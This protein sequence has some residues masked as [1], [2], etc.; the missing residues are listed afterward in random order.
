[1]N[2]ASRKTASSTR[3]R[4][5]IV[6]LAVLTAGHQGSGCSS[7]GDQDGPSASTTTTET[8][9]YELC[10]GACATAKTCR[11]LLDVDACVAQ[12]RHEVDGTG[13]LLTESARKYFRRLH[14]T[15]DDAGC[16]ITSW[17]AW[18]ADPFGDPSA[19]HPDVDD[20]ATL[21]ECVQALAECS[22]Q[23]TGFLESGCFW[24]YYR[25]NAERRALVRAC[26]TVSCFDPD[27]DRNLCPCSE[28]PE[29]EPWL[30]MPP[31]EPDP[32]QC[33]WAALPP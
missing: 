23:P 17:D 3:L 9:P 24:L 22:D 14:D 26:F 19:Y 32:G 31:P 11:G 29:G 15:A 10:A 21:T 16:E 25:H 5:A 4:A 18:L 33:P 20:P 28:Q 7:E 30:G 1:M 2:C 8:A 27:L 13:Y 6:L 12:C